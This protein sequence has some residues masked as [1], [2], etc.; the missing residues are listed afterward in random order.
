MTDLYSEE[1][2]RLSML[3]LVVERVAALPQVRAIVCHNPA[4]ETVG[5]ITLS[6]GLVDSGVQVAAGVYE[7]D[8]FSR[9][10]SPVA[11]LLRKRLQG[12]ALSVSEE[13]RIQKI[14]LIARRAL[15]GVTARALRHIAQQCDLAKIRIVE[16]DAPPS[17]NEER[18][19]FTVVE[20][21]LAAGHVETVR[22]AD[23]AARLYENPPGHPHER[24]LLEWQPDVRSGPW[25]IMTTRLSERQTSAVARFGLL[26]QTLA[27]PLSR[28]RL[29]GQAPSPAAALSSSD[30]HA[31]YT[32]VTGQYVT[33]LVYPVSELD[34]LIRSLEDFIF[35][36]SR[37]TP[38]ITKS[39]TESLSQRP[40]SP[41]RHKRIS[42]PP[43]GPLPGAAALPAEAPTQAQEEPAPAT[44]RPAAA[45]ASAAIGSSP[46]GNEA[47]PAPPG[48]TV[49]RPLLPAIA[50]PPGFPAEPPAPPSLPPLVDSIPTPSI[51]ADASAWLSAAGSSASPPAVATD[52]AVSDGPPAPPS[53]SLVASADPPLADSPA[54]PAAQHESAAAAPTP[55]LEFCGLTV[56][57]KGQM[58]I[59]P[60]SLQVA[61][62]GMH[63]WVVDGGVQHRLLLSLLTDGPMSGVTVTGRARF[64]GHDLFEPGAS[65]PH[66]PPRDTRAMMT[67]AREYLLDGLPPSKSP[68]SG[69]RL[70]S[71]LQRIEHAGFAD[72]VPHL[73]LRL[74]ELEPFHYRVSKVLRAAHV[75]PRLLLQDDPLHG[76]TPKQGERVLKLLSSEAERRAILILVSK[77]EPYVELNRGEPMQ[78]TWF[79]LSSQPVVIPSQTGAF[80]PVSPLAELPLRRTQAS[81]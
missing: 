51:Q 19:R 14:P 48:S 44:S 11:P 9:D 69:S 6:G 10:A 15:C 52:S 32:V 7:D 60:L 37:V 49:A 18:L 8:V 42:L 22:Y 80:E 1:F 30:L 2:R 40:L 61:S 53:L 75:G 21:L 65:R 57:V 24:W 72:L 45:T 20:L 66:L 25:P 59:A 62:R 4:G 12:G 68:C 47:V 27:R 23:A 31:Y 58:V 39:H 67:P 81:G 71:L 36:T 64:D 3:L 73:D 46:S 5:R 55:L 76:L 56:S 77:P 28:Q 33:L 26:A 63:L 29:A 17:R 38:Q 34:K 74:C 13:L 50:I 41:N 54:P 35:S 16:E 43:F 70:P 78:V 79:E